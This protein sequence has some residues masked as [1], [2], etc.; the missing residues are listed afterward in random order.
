MAMS[1]LFRLVLMIGAMGCGVGPQLEPVNERPLQQSDDDDDNDGEDDNE[2]ALSLALLEFESNLFRD[3]FVVG[4]SRAV[5]EDVMDFDNLADCSA[6][7]G[8]FC[9]EEFPDVGESV[10][11]GDFDPSSLTSFD[12]GDV[13]AAGIEVSFLDDFGFGIGFGPFPFSES[14]D[15]TITD[16]LL[17]GVSESNAFDFAGDIELV[18]PQGRLD[19]FFQVGPGDVLPLTWEASGPGDTYL[20]LVNLRSEFI[21]GLEDSGTLDLDIDGLG[22]PAPLARAQ[23][24]LHRTLFEDIELDD[25]EVV[26][27]TQ[28][29]VDVFIEYLDSD[30]FTELVAGTDLADDCGSAGALQPI[31]AGEFF[32]NLRGFTNDFEVDVDGALLTGEEGLV[33]VELDAGQTLDVLYALGVGS[34]HLVLIEGACDAG[35]VVATAGANPMEFGLPVESTLTFTN[36]SGAAQT[37]FL[38]FDA[39]PFGL[40][41][42]L[43]FFTASIAI[44]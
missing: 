30:G 16:G 9:V 5:D 14:R 21:L 33:K 38:A 17:D 29:S 39:V 12:P 25:T 37:Y 6:R 31:G 15:V 23:I 40:D 41:I 18:S 7:I 43:G 36:N 1:T 24:N 35:N 2:I 19:G 22:L 3:A 20:E 10:L 44:Q 27:H 4:I 32:G 28:R 13:V 34:A 26:V 11:P 8:A 42:D